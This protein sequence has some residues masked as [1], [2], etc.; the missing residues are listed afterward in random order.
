MVDYKE[1]IHVGDVIQIVNHSKPA[2]I[3]LQLC[4]YSISTFG[5]LLAVGL[6]LTGLKTLWEE[7]KNLKTTIKEC[8]GCD[9]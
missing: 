1:Y 3:I 5:V 8:G 9:Q 7:I 2:P 6:L 4:W